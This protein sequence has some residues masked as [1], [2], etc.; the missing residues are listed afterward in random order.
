M[1][2]SIITSSHSMNATRNAGASWS[3]F[4]TFDTPKLDPSAAGFTKHGI[5]IS[6]SMYASL[7]LF[8]SPRRS[9]RLLA[10]F[11]PQPRR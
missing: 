6:L 2:D 3:A 9:N 1:N 10:T 7:Y 5:P 4:F 11:T 8:S